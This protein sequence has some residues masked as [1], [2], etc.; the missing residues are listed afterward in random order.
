MAARDGRCGFAGRGSS[1]SV[2]RRAAEPLLFYEAV[3][4]FEGGLAKECNPSL[5]S[6]FRC[7]VK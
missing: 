7:G 1:R 3:L 2:I 6:R 4:T 5:R